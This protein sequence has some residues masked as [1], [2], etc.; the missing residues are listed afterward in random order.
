MESQRRFLKKAD[1]EM[2]SQCNRT[3]ESR[4]QGKIPGLLRAGEI[5]GGVALQ[6][7]WSCEQ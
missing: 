5:S 1:S 3:P 7:C 2:S 6:H 4:M